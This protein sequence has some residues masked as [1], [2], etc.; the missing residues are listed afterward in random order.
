MTLTLLNAE[1][2]LDMLKI[3][4]RAL[5]KHHERTKL[6]STSTKVLFS[7]LQ[8]SPPCIVVGSKLDP[9]L[10]RQIKLQRHILHEDV[11]PV[12]LAGSELPVLL[13]NTALVALC[14]AALA[15]I[16][17]LEDELETL[18]AVHT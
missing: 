18:R 17:K 2:P 3:K 1:T 11:Y 7:G 8:S 12:S 9:D 4:L 13:D 15:E 14:S 16:D 6:V 5:V 10:L